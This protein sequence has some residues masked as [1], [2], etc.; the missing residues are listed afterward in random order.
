MTGNSR[1]AAPEPGGGKRPAPGQPAREPLSAVQVIDYLRRHPDFLCDHPDVLDVL[2]PPA[3]TSGNGVADLQQFMVT[4]LRSEIADLQAAHDAMV[5]TSRSNLCA[6]ARVHK[7]ILLLL[8]ARS[9]EHFIETLTTDVAVV[10]DVDVVG[11]GVEQDRD[12]THASTPR[13]E[14]PGVFR[15]AA[16]AVDRLIGPGQ[17]VMLRADVDGDPAIFGPGAGLVHSQA[18]IRLTISSTTPCALLAFGSRHADK[19][20]PGQGTELLSFFARVVETSIRGWLNLPE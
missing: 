16:G 18:L 9:F 13:C 7:A 19:F 15:L 1:D 5:A 20:Q 11:I 8:G 2:R 4:R 14:T 12:C 10:L 3:R 17:Q 6:Q